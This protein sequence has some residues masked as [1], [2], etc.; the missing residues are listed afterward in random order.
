MQ[1]P[2]VSIHTLGVVAGLVPA[3]PIVFAV[4]ETRG[5]SPR[6]TPVGRQALRIDFIETLLE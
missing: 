6:V 1:L 3:T 5:T 4:I 2:L